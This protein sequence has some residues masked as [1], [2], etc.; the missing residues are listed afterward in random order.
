[1]A[2]LL[3]SGEEYAGPVGSVTPRLWTP[4]LRTLSPDTSYGFRFNDYCRDVLRDPNDEWQEWL[5]VH[6]GELLPDG[7]PRFRN[8]LILVARQQGKTRWAKKLIKFWMF[9]DRVPLVLGTS[10]NRQYAKACWQE[11]CDEVLDNPDLAEHLAEAPVRLTIGEEA[12]NSRYGQYRFAA[13]NRRAGRSMTVHRALLDELREH[14]T[15]DA[16]NAASK[17]MNAVRDGQLVAIT[18][19]GDG[20]SVVL[21]ALRNPALAFIETGDGDPRLGLFEYS[22]PPGS[23]PTDLHALAM[24]NPDLGGRTDPYVLLADG[25]RAKNAGGEELAGF[26]TEVMCM[27]V[28]LLNPAYDPDCWL[29]NGTDDPP[30]L[31]QHRR[32]VALC[33]DVSLDGLHATLTAAAKLDGIVHAEVVQAWTGRGCTKQLRQDLPGL[34]QKIR[35]RVLGWFPNGPA[36]AVAADLADRGH[37]DWPPRRVKVEAIKGETSAVCMG[38]E[39]LNIAGEIR[40]PK[41]PMLTAHVESAQKLERA[42]GTWVLTRKGTSPIDGA[43]SLAGAVHL[44]RTL[45]PAPHPV[46][47][48]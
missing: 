40:H 39:E 11:V 47:V 33:L 25:Q 7:R 44:A 38:L 42:D 3:L 36:A 37:R 13:S 43:Y 23:D 41:D 45:P 14:H 31:A 28:A 10:T 16:W 18:N 35:P 2:E 17:A 19:Q 21:D 1:V 32:Q 48:L 15:F 26:R 6:V 29:A 34:V 30:D 24:A 4:P 8:A 27:R 9:E 12:L 20:L 46:T 22:C 5:S